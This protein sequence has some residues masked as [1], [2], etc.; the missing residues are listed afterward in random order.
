MNRQEVTDQVI[1]LINPF[2][3]DKKALLNLTDQ[4]SIL[5]DLRVNSSR[6]VDIVLSFEDKFDIE[7]DDDDADRIETIGDA[8]NLVINKAS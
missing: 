1:Q 6:F 7:I 8:V 3:K 4:T 5:K 2:V